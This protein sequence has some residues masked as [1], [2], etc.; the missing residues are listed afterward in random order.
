MIYL[1][2]TH[3]L[4]WF[5]FNSEKLSKK[6]AEILVEP[7]NLIFVSAV[8]YWE[9]SIKYQKEKLNLGKFTPQEL[10]KIILNFGFEQIPL[11]IEEASSLF[12]LQANYHK[13]PF[14]RML[15]WQAIKNDFTLISD[16]ENVKK[17]ASESLKVIW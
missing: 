10:E 6:A 8:N 17:Y 11:T 5:I 14:D 15:I 1:V 4:I 12:K 3:I 16:D 13:D 7:D 9:I 2:D